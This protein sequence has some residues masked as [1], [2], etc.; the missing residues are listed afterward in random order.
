MLKLALSNAKWV[1]TRRLFLT[2]NES[3][4]GQDPHYDGRMRAIMTLDNLITIEQ[5]ERFLDGSTLCTYRPLDN[6]D[7]RYHWIQSTLVRFR[8]LTRKKR[9]KGIIRRFISKISGYSLQQVT[10]LITQYKKTGKCICGRSSG[11]Q[12]ACRY[13]DTDIRRLAQLDQLHDAPCGAVVKKL[14]ERALAQGETDYERLARISASHVYNLR[15]SNTYQNQRPHFTKTQP[16]NRPLVNAVNPTQKVCLA[17]CES[18]SYIKAIKTNKKGF[19]LLTWLT[20]KP[21]LKFPS[22]LSESVRIL[23]KTL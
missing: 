19:I 9:E 13:S 7:E 14:C 15:Q 21:S 22:A 17:I 20:K 8:Y 1:W 12:F 4:N 18:I 6:K 11:G 5:W 16:K 3:K 23:W 10:R 2:H